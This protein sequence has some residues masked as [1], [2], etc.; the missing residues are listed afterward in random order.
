M[1]LIVIAVIVIV[2]SCRIYPLFKQCDSH[3]GTNKL[4][5]GNSTICQAGAAVTSVAMGIAAVGHNYDPA[6][7]NTWLIENDGYVAGDQLVWSAVRKTGVSYNGTFQSYEGKV[8][9]AMIKNSLDSNSI[10]VCNV[11]NGSHWVVA[12]GY[13]GNTIMVNDPEFSTTSYT[14]SEIVE[15]QNVV[16]GVSQ[17]SQFF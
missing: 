2:T 8:S 10:V 11:R 14:L 1:K 9:N 13:K 6:T 5:T 17:R 7:L 16:Y 4:G 3:W 12:T 15:G